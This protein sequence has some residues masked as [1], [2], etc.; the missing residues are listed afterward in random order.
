MN[1]LRA[2]AR[3][4]AFLRHL[5]LVRPMTQELRS[6]LLAASA[7]GA[8]AATEWHN[9]QTRAAEL[10]GAAFGYAMA[11]MTQ[12]ALNVDLSYSADYQKL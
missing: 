11:S 8:E 3:S 7:D 2:A 6:E 5:I 12:P 4:L 10:K 9:E 1:K